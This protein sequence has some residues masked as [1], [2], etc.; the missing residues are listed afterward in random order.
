MK[1]LFLY[2]WVGLASVTLLPSCDKDNPDQNN[3]IFDIDPPYRNSFD[4]WLLNN[5]VLPYNI[6]VY[7]LLKDIETDF[8]YNVV[9]AE[10]HK[11]KQ[12][13]FLLKYLWLEAYEAVAEDGVHFVRATVPRIFHYVGSAEYNASGTI[14][15]GVAE[16]GAKITITQV[17]ELD[18][19]NIVNQ[20]FFNTIHHEYG[21]ILH[22]MKPFTPEFNL[23]SAADYLPTSWHNRQ[24][25]AAAQAGF[26]SQYAGKLPSEDFVEVLARYIT[27]TPA[28]WEAKLVQAVKPAVPPIGNDPGEREDRSGRE[29]I[30]KKLDFVKSYMKSTWGVDI[31]QLKAEIQRRAHE[32][33]YMDFDNLGF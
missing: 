2:L 30:E 15:L 29:K 13:A 1:K 28:Q 19:Y 8:T 3:S 24:E 7:Y 22:Q 27:W 4:T 12:M 23:I 16:G 6:Q 20:N 9:P 17:N 14:R 32:I 21:H 25:V 5:Y 11:A 31:D 26:V 10:L 33:Q 18:P